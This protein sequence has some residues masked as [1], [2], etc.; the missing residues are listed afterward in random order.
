MQDK[1]KKLLSVLQEFKSKKDL[2]PDMLENVLRIQQF[3]HEVE[4]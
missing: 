1:T 2:T 3:V 4:S